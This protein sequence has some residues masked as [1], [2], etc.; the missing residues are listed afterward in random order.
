[1]GHIESSVVISKHGLSM[2][3]TR[4]MVGIGLVRSLVNL[5]WALWRIFGRGA[6]RKI[7]KLFM[8]FIFRI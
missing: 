1:M 6:K 8:I 7:K 3:N 2:V 4:T 5:F